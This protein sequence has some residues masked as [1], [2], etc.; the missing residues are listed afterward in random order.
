MKN[1]LLKNVVIVGGGT[2]GWMSAAL[3]VKT[4]GDKINITLVESD[5]IS[6]IGVGEATIPPI[7]HFN[8]QLGIDPKAFLSATKAT[9]K[10]GIE[11]KNWG[12]IDNTYM[13]AF[14][15]VGKSFPFCD[16][17][18]FW[19]KA[20]KEGKQYNFWDFS[21]NYQAA[22]RN[23]FSPLEKIPGIN[24][25]GLSFA[26]HFDAGLY[27]QFLRKYSENLGVN[28]IE[29]AVSEIQ[30][31][32]ETSAIKGLKLEGKE[33]EISG[34]LFIDCT[35]LH[36]LLIEKTLNTGFEDWSHW[37][38]ADSAIAVPSEVVHPITPYTSST[39]HESSWQ[40]RIPLQ[41]RIGNGIV[42]S[43]KYMTDEEAEATLLANLPSKAIGEPKRIKFKTGRRLKQWNKNV[44]SIGLSSGFLEPL[45]S[46]SIHLIQSSIVRL[47]KMF[48]HNGISNAVVN[49]FN[50]QS[51][52]EVEKIRD[53][54]IL[55][56]KVN[57]RADSR[58]WR[59]CQAME[60]PESL[61]HKIDV[62]K[63]SGLVFRESDELFAK[64]AWQ[65]VCIG[66]GLIPKD[67]HSSANVLTEQD[68]EEMLDNIKEVIERT[69]DKLPTHQS[70]LD[71][72]K[73]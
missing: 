47:I 24:L 15:D 53:F 10:L 44:V 1:K 21:L 55:H 41:H 26:F 37:L 52:V 73:H 25:S 29:G 39:A 9:I 20:N 13:H 63:E 23:A 18:H 56:Y 62:F 42:Y 64:L 60:I 3:L 61:A 70:Y 22:K 6:T 48:P 2:A 17:N 30:Q 45:E 33:L 11:F 14:G 71:A 67:Y 36:S 49:E 66:Q 19:L 12:H 31:C 35:G 7:I 16:F 4:F 27:A 8:N 69:A 54:I 72:S 46:T 5:K 59:D 34:D 58:F 50:R 32:E 51:K 68:T 43:S 38:P 57:Q 65:Q 28:R 40:W